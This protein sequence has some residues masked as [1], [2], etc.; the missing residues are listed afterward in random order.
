M[1]GQNIFSSRSFFFFFFLFFVVALYS[2]KYKYS[3]LGVED[4]LSQITVSDICQDEKSR[5]WIATLDG[6][7]CFDGNQIRV[8]NHFQTDSISYGNLHVLQMV[9]DGEGS[10]FLLTLTGV[11][12]FDLETEE[13]YLLPV[14]YPSALAKGEKGLWIAENG[15]LFLYNKS[16]D[17]LKEMYTDKNLP[18]SGPS[19]LEDKKGVLWLALKEGGVLR[20]DTKGDSKAL[21]S[22]IKF[23]KLIEGRDGNVWMGSPSDG[24][25]CVSSEGEII[26]HYT[27]DA[28]NKKSLRND[29]A[30]ALTQDFEGNVWVGYR[31]GLSKIEVSTGE[32]SHFQADPN[33][34]GALSSNSVTSLYT[35]NQGVVWIGTY[36]GGVNFFSPEYQHYIHYDSSE[37]GL[38]APV[39]GAMTEDTKGNIWICTEGGGLNLYDPAADEF[40]HFNAQTGHLFSSNYL[41]DI[42]FDEENNCLWI[43]ADYSNKINCFHLDGRKNNIYTISIEY[44]KDIGE[45]LFALANTPSSLFIGTTSTVICLNKQTLKADI[46]FQQDDLFTH[47]YNSL[48]LDSKERLWYASDK[49]CVAYHIQERRFD[50][51][52]INLKKKVL[53]QKELVNTIYE[54][55]EGDIWIGTHGNG[56]FLLDTKTHSFNLH[57]DE[58]L[59]SGDNIRVLSETPSGALLIGTG[60]GLSKLD[61]KIN[62]ILNFNSKRGFPLSMINRKSLYVSKANDI[63]MGGATGMIVMPES[64][65]DYPSKIYDLQLSHLYVNNKEVRVRDK[66]GILD[67]DFAYTT[68]IDLKHSEN[69]FSIGFSTDNFLKLGGSEILYRLVGYNEDWTESRQGREITYTNISPGKYNFELRL[70]NHPE[71]TKQLIIK[72]APPFYASWWAYTLYILIILVILFFIIREYRIRVYLKTSLDFEVREKQHI[73]EM[74]QSKL[75]FFTNI[76]HEI[77][78][79][80]TLILGQVDLLLNSGKLS[81]YAYSKL[82]NIHKN[83]TSL[84]ALITELLDFRKQEQGLLKL[85]IS[86]FDLYSLLKE[87]HMLFKE[88]AYNRNISFLFLSEAEPCLIWGDRLQIQKVINNLLSNAFKY[89]A[90]GGT[91]RIELTEENNKCVFSVSDDGVGISEEDYTKIFERFYQVENIGL[92]EGTGIGLALSQGIIKAHKGEITVLSTAGK[93]SCFKVTLNKDDSGFDSSVVRLST[94][95][96]KEYVFHSEDKKALEKEIQ[97]IQSKSQ[98]YK[99]LIVDDNEE[100]RHILTD[101]LSPLYKVTTAENGVEGYNK[102]KEFMPDLIISDIMMPE[103]SGTEL[104]SKIKNNIETCHIPVILLTALG[105][106][107]RELEGL[108]LGAD[109]YIVKPFNIRRLVMQCNNLINSRRTLQEKYARQTDIKVNKIATNELD[110]TFLEEAI[111]IVESNINNSDFNVEVFSKE[112]GVGRTVL[113]QKIKGITGSTP[114]NFIMNLRLK[115]ATDLLI[116]SPEMNISDIAYQLGFENPQ[117]FTKCFKKL[118]SKTPSEYRNFQNNSYQR[119]IE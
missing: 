78:T 85:R 47:N 37:G 82:L 109:A 40:S 110:Q 10:L 24:V 74:N 15:K 91:I 33:R 114:N 29:M 92:N 99:L 36:W 60:H 27:Y 3:V 115:K 44:G 28:N 25:L 76:S 41:K 46:L 96:E 2:Q 117:Y 52:K 80:I 18:T 6:L 68:Q 61:K 119:N 55:E 111:S 88:F 97:S 84:K 75:R 100:I 39:V 66:T 79:P 95:E 106:L 73:E 9:E 20:I 5:I 86:Q 45:A 4:G 23:M 98:D 21:F 89:T 104:C 83:A 32:I 116:N 87:H 42:V 107:E 1:C 56:L 72:I 71:V 34:M 53:S 11:F 54:D 50:V 35:D 17:E 7:N 30:R 105:T 101:I 77:R 38:S 81:T 112:M 59:L 49:G 70:K 8:F 69:I 65:L 14:F 93:G 58:N 57:T 118:F 43:A 31:S 64:S 108:R 19:M 26:N 48:L 103:M 51:Y 22:S 113:F 13:F 12:R 94:L 67:Q 90:D 62:K 102:V 63:F 16:S